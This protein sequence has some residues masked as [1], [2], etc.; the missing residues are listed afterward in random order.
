MCES[1][2]SL[3]CADCKNFIGGGDWSLCCKNPPEDQVGWCCFLCYEDTEACQNFKPKSRIKF[4]QDKPG[5][6][7]SVEYPLHTGWHSQ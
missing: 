3:R 1:K 7:E 6:W 2:E 4:R 5:D